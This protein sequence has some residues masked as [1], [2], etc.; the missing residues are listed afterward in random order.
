MKH[1]RKERT[2]L[3]LAGLAALMTGAQ[4]SAQTGEPSTALD[5]IVVT[6]QKREQNVQDVP[7]AID[8]V[9]RDKIL[10]QRIAGPDD[11]LKLL[12]NLSLKTASAVNSG[13]AIRGVGTQ[14][15]HLTAQQAVGLYFDEV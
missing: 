15:F 5:E 14:N 9:S 3:A 1:R 4:L 12:P 11:L 13:F 6:A 10:A 2:T 7:I 8:A